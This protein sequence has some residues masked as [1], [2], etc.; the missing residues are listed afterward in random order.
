MKNKKNKKNIKIITKSNIIDM[1]IVSWYNYILRFYIYIVI[2][3][4][5]KEVKN[6]N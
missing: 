3:T 4:Y 2:F 6:E 1:H 5:I